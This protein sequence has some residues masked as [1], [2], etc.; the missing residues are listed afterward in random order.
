MTN[1]DKLSRGNFGNRFGVLVAMTGSAVGLGNLWRFPYLVGTNGGAA[2]ICIYLFFVIVICLPIMFSEFVIG[3]RSRANAV[4]AYRSLAPGSHWGTA[5]LIAVICSFVI[6]SFYN[7]VGGWTINYLVRALTFSL[8]SASQATLSQLFTHV[9]SDVWLP[10]LTMFVFIAITA[11]VVA[12]GVEKGIEKCAKI[13]MP[14]LFV[15]VVIIAVRSLTLKGAAAG[16]AFLFKPDFS[17]VTADTFLEAMGQA[18]FSLSLGAGMVMTYA[19]YVKKDERI[20]Q[21]SILIAASDTL[22]AILAG[23]AIMPAVF[24]FGISPGEG[25]GLVFVTLP[26]VFAQI[27]GG[28]IMA[29]LFFFILF[30]AA[31][32]SSISLMEVIVAYLKEEFHLRRSTAVAVT[33]LLIT[34][35]GALCSLS[36]GP[37]AKCTILGLTIFDLFD[38]VSANLLLTLG[39]LLA[40]IF[41]GWKL[42]KSDF[43]DELTNG[44][45][46]HISTVL[47]S[48]IYFIV[49]YIAPC[50]IVVIM[51]S[52]LIH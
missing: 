26:H 8:T 13:M 2:F 5:G 18:F 45:T 19:S 33:A 14:M 34:A 23:C 20:I 43:T 17:A 16:I 32:T 48:V 36:Q 25:P 35:T 52:G 44:G 37:L 50:V 12:A 11:L 47:I 22:F 7:V 38:Y 9:A 39:G 29:I 10:L 6:I 41:M 3:R 4:K 30:I 46:L 1:T 24:A 28:N 15:L 27:P 51:A 40:V 49:K 42:K 31:L 21:S